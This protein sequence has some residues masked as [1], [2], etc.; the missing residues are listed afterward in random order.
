MVEI[1]MNKGMVGIMTE[2][3]KID[4]RDYE[5]EIKDSNL[6]KVSLCPPLS[7]S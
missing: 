7:F 5:I 2:R 6:L 1:K 4:G 3:L